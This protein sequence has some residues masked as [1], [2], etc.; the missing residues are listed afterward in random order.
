MAIDASKATDWTTDWYRTA[1][2]GGLQTGTGLLFDM[3]HPVTITGIQIILGSAA[4]ADLQVRTGQA[5][6]LTRMRPQASAGDAS[7]TVHLSL[8]RPHRARYLLVWLTQ[9]PLDSAGTF[10]ASVY[11]VR[12]KGFSGQGHLER[13]H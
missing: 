10:K 1:H 4:G 2:F 9:L 12:M 11:D 6:T 7:G 8:A 3:G 5:P 13:A